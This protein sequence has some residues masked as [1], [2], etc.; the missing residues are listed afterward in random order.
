MAIITSGPGQNSYVTLEEANIL[1]LQVRASFMEPND[2]LHATDEDVLLE[3]AQDLETMWEWQGVQTDPNQDMAWPRKYVVKPGFRYPPAPG[4][5]ASWDHDAALQFKI[6]FLIGANSA[7]PF[8]DE[9]TVPHQ[10]K[11]AQALLALLRDKGKNLIGDTRGDDKGMQ[12]DTGFKVDYV[13]APYESA[14]IRKR[15]AALGT[16]IG[17]PMIRARNV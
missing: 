10:I 7:I 5:H 13:N 14:D 11:V 8:L 12:L 2:Q 1:L 15:V 9:N 17:D 16:F 4:W 6:N 3:A